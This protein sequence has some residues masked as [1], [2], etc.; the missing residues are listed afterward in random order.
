MTGA[1]EGADGDARWRARPAQDEGQARRQRTSA[2][3]PNEGGEKASRK[4]VE[5][6]AE[7]VDDGTGAAELAV[8]A[9]V[10]ASVA[11]IKRFS[12]ARVVSSFR[13]VESVAIFA[14][15]VA[16]TGV[17]IREGLE[18]AVYQSGAANAGFDSVLFNVDVLALKPVI[19][20]Y[21]DN[22]RFKEVTQYGLPGWIP[23][24]CF[25]PVCLI[26]L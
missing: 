11:E 12:C 8:P 13:L 14:L 24:I 5:A 18:L 21:E 23:S 10:S 22:F 17:G 6:A 4:A 20:R 16:V 1:G 19:V 3:M 9:R 7:G 25:F 15:L 2:V 26:A